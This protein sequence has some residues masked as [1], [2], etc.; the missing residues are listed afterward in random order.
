VLYHT[1]SC[2]SPVLAAPALA[3]AAAAPGAG[4]SADIYANGGGVVVS[5]FEWVQNLQNLQWDEEEVNRRLDRCVVVETH[6]H[7]DVGWT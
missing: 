7:L 6:A 4:T 2:P 5:F 1:A 3:V